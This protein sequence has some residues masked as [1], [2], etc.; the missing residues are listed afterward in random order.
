MPLSLNV[1][2]VGERMIFRKSH[3]YTAIFFLTLFVIYQY[4]ILRIYGM[5][6]YPDEFGYWSTAAHMIGWDWSQVASRGSYY[7]FGYSLILIPILKFCEDSV[8]AYRVAVFVNFSFMAISFFLLKEIYKRIFA[9]QVEGEEILAIGLAVLYPAWS[10]YAQIT[11]VDSLLIFMVILISYLWI[12]FVEVP[13]LKW[14]IA[15]VAAVIYNYSLHMRSAGILVAVVMILILWVWKHPSYWKGVFFLLL[16][17]I[18]LFWGVGWTKGIVQGNVFAEAS[19]ESLN[20]NDFGGQWSKVDFLLSPEGLKQ[21]FVIVMGKVLYLGIAGAGLAY[22]AFIW[23]GKQ[24]AEW[25]KREV[26]AGNQMGKTDFFEN[27]VIAENENAV[28]KSWFGV[29]LTLMVLGQLAVCVIYTIRTNNTDW[30]V[31][32]RYIEAFVPMTIFVGTSYVL[33]KGL[34]WKDWTGF[35]GIY[36]LAALACICKVWGKTTDNI[37]GVHSVGT[38][39]LI[40]DGTVEP[41]KFFLMAWGVGLLIMILAGC[42]LRWFREDRFSISIMAIV[43]AV[44]AIW[45]IHASEKYTYLAN[46]NMAGELILVNVLEEQL[47]EE[48]KIYYLEEKNENW[49]SYVQ[50]QLRE[51][52]LS[53]IS[54]EELEKLD[55]E[56][57]AVVVDGETKCM[58]YM[59]ENYNRKIAGNY[60]YVFYNN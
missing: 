44:L 58:E 41:V 3:I 47:A 6:E 15:L 4:G 43:C 5:S 50:M 59:E 33:Q 7:S 1:R 34:S 22:V 46:E 56:K 25:L 39:F 30:L 17:V 12:R 45:S 60:H 48:K 13:N 57:S 20:V 18:G 49:I 32:G 9:E 19:K 37:R 23:C 53:V 16:A 42:L 55:L 24:V 14:G 27:G 35:F 54:I 10:F 2:M 28:V 8:S 51:Q 31:Y 21:A 26:F 38:S 52:A 29:L 36:T 11:L 40:G